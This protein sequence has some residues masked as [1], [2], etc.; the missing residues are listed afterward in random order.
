MHLCNDFV[1]QLTPEET[2]AL[3]SAAE[4]LMKITRNA[5]LL[6]TQKKALLTFESIVDMTFRPDVRTT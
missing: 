3:N 2:D 4:V 1:L 5:P 6:E